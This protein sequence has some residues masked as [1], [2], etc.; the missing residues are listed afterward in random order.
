[1]G[2]DCSVDMEAVGKVVVRRNLVEVIES[3]RRNLVGVAAL[4]IE[5]QSKGRMLKTVYDSAKAG[6]MAPKVVEW[7]TL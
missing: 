7:P 6:R 1:M 3:T 5:S 4:R 2:V